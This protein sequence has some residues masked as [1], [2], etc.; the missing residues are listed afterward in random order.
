MDQ[1]TVLPSTVV[2]RS[3]GW[4]P[5][6]EFSNGGYPPRRI[7]IRQA[8]VRWLP[9]FRVPKTWRDRYLCINS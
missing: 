6:W 3:F 7:P 4:G 8:T 9:L 2:P 5:S 1:A